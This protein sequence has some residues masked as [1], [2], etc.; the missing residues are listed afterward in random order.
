MASKKSEK[1]ARISSFGG[2]AVPVD[3]LSELL[4][5]AYIVTSSW[6]DGR[7]CITKADPITT[8]TFHD[9]NEIEAAI[10]QQRLSGN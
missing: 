6:E 7:E 5:R 1:F 4:D 3:L 2:I 10:V 9:L 8:A